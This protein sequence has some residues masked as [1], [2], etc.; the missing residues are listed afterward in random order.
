MLTLL[1]YRRQVSELY[2][3]LR[4]EGDDPQV[5]AWFR[6]QRDELFRTHPQSAL[7]AGQKARFSG[8]AYYDYDPACRVVAQVDMNITPQSFRVDL[9]E[10]GLLAYWRFGRVS[11]ELPTG[12]GTLSL[13][14]LNGYGGGVFLPFGDA[15]NKD[16]TYGGGRYLYDTIKGADLGATNSEI[17]LDF[18]YAYHPSCAYNPRW[19]CPLTP[20]E[21][22]LAFPIPAGEKLAEAY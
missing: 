4:E 18:N 21:N 5:C 10:D 16:T 19:V 17:V 15:T 12:A 9:G 1:D 13:F 20:P 2:R 3:V 14:W 11:F 6:H 8:L 7:D 22:R